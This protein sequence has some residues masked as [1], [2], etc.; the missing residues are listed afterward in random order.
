MNF[1]WQ[2]YRREIFSVL[3]KMF[4][5]SN[6]MQQGRY[7]RLDVGASILF[8]KI[9]ATAVTNPAK[10]FSSCLPLSIFYGLAIQSFTIGTRL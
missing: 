4:V 3:T 9:G 1:C 10:W 2:T 5:T 6:Y 7:N 8:E